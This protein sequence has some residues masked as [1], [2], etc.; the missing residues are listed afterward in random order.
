[1][2]LIIFILILT[3]PIPFTAKERYRQSDLHAG[4]FYLQNRKIQF[5]KRLPPSVSMQMLEKQLKSFNDPTS[6]MQVKANRPD[7]MNG[8][9]IRYQLD[10][11]TSG[12][13]SRKIP[14]FLKQPI[15]ATFEVKKDGGDY[16]VR[17]TNMWFNNAINPGSQQ[18]ITLESMTLIKNGFAFT[19]KKRTLRAL[20][21][22]DEN[23]DLM[24]SG[25]AGSRF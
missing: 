20:S 19:R 18:H 2:K 9:M 16:L 3:L 23:L 1:M 11:T 4:N 8:V 10:W 15:N 14:K 13:R 25:G 21:V 7:G 17:V 22:L 24:F 6:G 5:E 12:F